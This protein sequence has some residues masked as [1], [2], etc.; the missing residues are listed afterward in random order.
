MSHFPGPGCACEKCRTYQWVTVPKETTLEHI[1][2]DIR[3]GRFPQ[4][5]E[6]GACKWCIEGAPR[7]WSVYARVWMHRLPRLDRR[8]ENPPN[9]PDPCPDCGFTKGD[10][11][12]HNIP[13]NNRALCGHGVTGPLAEMARKRLHPKQDVPELGEVESE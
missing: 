13:G 7:E 11:K 8:C 4:K 10:G 3:E 9:Y 1:A 12:F 2:R 5:S 6:V